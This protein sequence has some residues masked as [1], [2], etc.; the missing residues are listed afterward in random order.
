MLLFTPT[1]RTSDFLTPQYKKKS[2]QTYKTSPLSYKNR[3]WEVTA[4]AYPKS[5]Q[6]KV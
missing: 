5:E 2:F 3:N 4:Q 6:A 1:Y